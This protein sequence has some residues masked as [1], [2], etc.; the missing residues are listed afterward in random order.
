MSERSDSSVSDIWA[1]YQE[2][3]RVTSLV[4]GAQAKALL[5]DDRRDNL[6]PLEAILQ[7]LPGEPVAGESGAA[8]LKQL[9]IGDFA[10]ILLDAPMPGMDGVETAG[11]I[12]QRGP[13]PHVPTTFLPAPR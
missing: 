9:L 7:G 3:S 8:A 13:H 11:H 2:V 12:N 1:G 4:D 6:I 10:G 5:V